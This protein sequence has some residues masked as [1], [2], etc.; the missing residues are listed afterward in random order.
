MHLLQDASRQVLQDG[1]SDVCG[2]PFFQQGTA[3]IPE[4]LPPRAERK[5]P[6]GRPHPLCR[7]GRRFRRGD[8]EYERV[9]SHWC[10]S[11]RKVMIIAVE[12][13]LHRRLL[14]PKHHRT[15][16]LG[17]VNQPTPSVFA[18][19]RSDHIWHPTSPL[20]RCKG[21]TGAPHSAPHELRREDVVKRSPERPETQRTPGEAALPPST[22]QDA[23]LCVC[24]CVCVCQNKSARAM[25]WES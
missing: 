13:G 7:S 6:T 3:R 15:L 5:R 20:E 25:W 12:A 9:P 11:R 17:K 4:A 1:P 21:R 24:M 16:H 23:C 2:V 19:H 14:A 8:A 10:R 22:L 18:E